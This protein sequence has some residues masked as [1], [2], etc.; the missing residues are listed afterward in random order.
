MS[1]HPLYDTSHM[2]AT[3]DDLEAAVSACLHL[4]R[5]NERSA[6]QWGED[7]P[8]QRAA[9]KMIVHHAFSQSAAKWQGVADRLQMILDIRWENGKEV[10][11]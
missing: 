5:D 7:N 9:Q 1:L 4:A 11:R 3:C 6:E 8:Q 2:V 10:Q